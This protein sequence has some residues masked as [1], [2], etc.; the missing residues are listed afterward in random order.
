M[1]TGC[2]ISEGRSARV[3]NAFIMI[4]RLGSKTIY[5][6]MRFAYVCYAK[7]VERVVNHRFAAR[8]RYSINYLV[9][10][11]V[12]LKSRCGLGG[13][14]SFL[15]SEPNKIVCFALTTSRYYC[16]RC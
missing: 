12:R 1:H 2:A 5:M 10:H 14:F 6:Y 16:R 3:A 11:Y 8:L 9:E 4:L 7:D 13:D 15:F